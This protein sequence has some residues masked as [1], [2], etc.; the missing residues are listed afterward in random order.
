MSSTETYA[1]K[2]YREEHKHLQELGTTIKVYTGAKA[3]ALRDADAKQKRALKE[4]LLDSVKLT[5]KGYPKNLS[6]FEQFCHDTY[7]APL[8]QE[9]QQPRVLSGLYYELKQIILAHDYPK[10]SRL[11]I[12]EAVR[13]MMHNA[14]MDNHDS[15]QSSM[16][17]HSL[18]VAN[19][20][21]K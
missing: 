6:F 16:F 11:R 10:S 12:A 8:D 19:Q 1:K 9:L 13:D 21:A 3:E 7:D 20:R 2:L 15:T 14:R 5:S 17:I 18:L 4:R